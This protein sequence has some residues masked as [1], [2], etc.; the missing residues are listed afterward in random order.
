MERVP[1]AGEEPPK[2]KRFVRW[3]EEAMEQHRRDHGTLHEDHNRRRGL[4]RRAAASFDRGL[5]YGLCLIQIL[6]GGLTIGDVVLAGAVL[7]SIAL[8]ATLADRDR[9]WS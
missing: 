3:T 1:I 4:R 6:R 8:H 2:P 9:G 5:L 7:A